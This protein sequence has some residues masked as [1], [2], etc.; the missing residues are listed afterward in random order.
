MFIHDRVPPGV[1]VM[2]KKQN[3]LTYTYELTERGARLRIKSQDTDAV[4]AIHE[5]LLFQIQDHRTGDLQTVVT[6][7]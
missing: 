3:V 7:H 2:K 1:P 5:F 6:D 4:K